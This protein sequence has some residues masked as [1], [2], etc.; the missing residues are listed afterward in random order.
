MS[1]LLTGK[2]RLLSVIVRISNYL[3]ILY[4]IKESQGCRGLD[5]L[6]TACER[7]WGDQCS[8]DIHKVRGE[9]R[10]F[11]IPYRAL[12]LKTNTGRG[13]PRVVIDQEKSSSCGSWDLVGLRLLQFTLY[14]VRSEYGMIDDQYSF[15]SISD[16]KLHNV[17]VSVI[18]LTGYNMIR[19]VLCSHGIHVSTPHIQQCISNVDPINTPM[20]WTA[21]TSRWWYSLPY[22][23]Y[24]WHIDGNHKLVR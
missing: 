5:I 21:P 1:A 11:N 2:V 9:C 6:T 23:N 15:T 20:R 4:T 3:H 7:S 18:Y 19:G 13:R 17:V 24:T 14:T 10:F 12:R 22:S 8:M 16:Q